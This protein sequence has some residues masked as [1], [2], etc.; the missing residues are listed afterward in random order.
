MGGRRIGQTVPMILARSE[1]LTPRLESQGALWTLANSNL[2]GSHVVSDKHVG[3]SLL[4][5]RS[6]FVHGQDQRHFE[7]IK[8]R[9]SKASQERRSKIIELINRIK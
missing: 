4:N 2:E 3:E 7:R 9:R 6:V 8:R 1:K 5:G